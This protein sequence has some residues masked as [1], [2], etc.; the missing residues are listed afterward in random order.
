MELDVFQCPVDI[1]LIY[2]TFGR[3]GM[4]ACPDPRHRLIKGTLVQVHQPD[5]IPRLGKNLR[6]AVSHDTGANDENVLMDSNR[7]R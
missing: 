6:N 1:F 5:R 3:K 7:M 2:M 4:Q